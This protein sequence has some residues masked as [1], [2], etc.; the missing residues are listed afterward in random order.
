MIRKRFL[1]LSALGSIAIIAPLAINSCSITPVPEE[2]KVEQDLSEQ[3]L[4]I[5]YPEEVRTNI[6]AN[7]ISTDYNNLKR[8]IL[9][10]NNKDNVIKDGQAQYE[11][12][13][14]LRTF[15]FSEAKKPSYFNI[16]ESRKEDR[17]HNIL[18]LKVTLYNV[19]NQIIDINKY[20]E[21]AL[22]I[23]HFDLGFTIQNKLP[24][25]KEYSVDFK[26]AIE[27][28]GRKELF[29]Q[30]ESIFSAKKVKRFDSFNFNNKLLNDLKAFD[31]VNPIPSENKKA[32]STPE[33]IKVLSSRIDSKEYFDFNILDTEDIIIDKT[34]VKA[35]Y[36]D[37]KEFNEVT[38]NSEKEIYNFDEVS[39]DRTK[40]ISS[41]YVGISFQFKT[42]KDDI[43]NS[44]QLSVLPQINNAYYVA[45][46]NLYFPVSLTQVDASTEISKISSNINTQIVYAASSYDDNVKDKIN[47]L[48]DI[49]TDGGDSLDNKPAWLDV[50][51]EKYY[52]TNS[53]S[54]WT[55]MTNWLEQPIT[56]DYSFR[57]LAKFIVKDDYSG[58]EIFKTDYS[59][60][61][62]LSDSDQSE[63]FNSNVAQYSYFTGTSFD[64]DSATLIS[65]QTHENLKH[66][67]N[68]AFVTRNIDSEG[69]VSYEKAKSLIN[70]INS[71]TSKGWDINGMPFWNTTDLPV[72]AMRG[73]PNSGF[74]KGS[75]R[76]WPT[77]FVNDIQGA[78]SKSYLFIKV[79]FDNN[80]TNTSR[81]FSPKKQLIIQFKYDDG[82]TASYKSQEI[83]I[84][85][86]VSNIADVNS[87]S[88]YFDFLNSFFWDDGSSTKYR[89]SVPLSNNKNIISASV[90]LEQ[91]SI[92]NQ[93]WIN[94][95]V[96][97]TFNN[98]N[99]NSSEVIN[100]A[101]P[102]FQNFG[103]FLSNSAGTYKGGFINS[104]EWMMNLPSEV[105]AGNIIINGRNKWTDYSY[106]SFFILS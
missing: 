30:K 21:Q 7:K 23:D 45:D 69:F 75:V 52:R 34:T 106:S 54:N 26:Y 68:Q 33:F 48:K 40:N 61:I 37:S 25:S 98:N 3:Y 31:Y 4:N 44:L 92:Y 57:F 24:G 47:E 39:F 105:G 77:L 41:K 103:I 49:M 56:K 95:F 14:S 73:K 78:S 32:F 27:I 15:D 86:Y 88:S 74:F 29:E 9:F 35:K 89:Y 64:P 101:R 97:Y 10:A 28:T 90:S 22:D 36:Y 70:Y 16:Y 87:D 20:R 51:F 79:S 83:K 38:T 66:F 94:F 2:P 67:Y 46:V 76:E 50:E 104:E 42:I 5:L 63:A 82:S 17:Y 85:Y 72:N 62:T 59:S 6:N 80:Y 13:R 11:F 1:G 60:F 18:N 71:D 19:F 102:V 99:P 81:T 65:H 43:L 100:A 8:L 53:D 55:K 93:A 58:G 91:Y 84:N 12:L 96:A